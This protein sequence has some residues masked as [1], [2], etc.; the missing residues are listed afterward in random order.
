MVQGGERRRR[1]RARRTAGAAW[2]PMS[3][4]GVRRG[5]VGRGWGAYRLKGRVP[6]SLVVRGFCRSVGFDVQL[7]AEVMLRLK[8]YQSEAP[9]EDTYQYL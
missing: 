9:V 6:S 4:G 1:S 5:V 2:N 7:A 8:A 3:G